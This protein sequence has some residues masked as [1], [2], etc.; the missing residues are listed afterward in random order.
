MTP[1]SNLVILQS[2]LDELS[3]ALGDISSSIET[4]ATLI[5][6]D[7]QLTIIN[8]QVALSSAAT[9]AEIIDN[10]LAFIAAIPLLG[11]DYQPDVPMHIG[12]EQ[13]AAGLDEIPDTLETLEGNLND[14]SS[15]LDVFSED[16][17]NLS[18]NMDVFSSDLGEIQGTLDDYSTIVDH[19][20]AKINA[21]QSHLSGYIWI[22]CIFLS[23]VLLWLGV[24]QANVLMQGLALRNNELEV[25]NL[26][27]LTRE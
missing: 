4:S 26:A 22:C 24:A 2:S 27:D 11:A 14:T 19:S 23:G 7:L 1:I 5:G 12:L 15:S 21:F 10:T 13:V 16:L 25:V 3:T 17:T 8:T 18:E 6:N 9:S 20:L